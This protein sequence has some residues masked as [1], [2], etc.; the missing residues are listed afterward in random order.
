MKPWYTHSN[1]TGRTP[2]T[3]HEA[4]GTDFSGFQQEHPGMGFLSKVKHFVLYL[5]IVCAT[6]FA[7]SVISGAVTM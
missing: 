6:V 4:F 2:R 7:I 3:M 5:M 1:W